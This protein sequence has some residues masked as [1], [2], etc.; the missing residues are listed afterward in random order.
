MI[1]LP[2]AIKVGSS[3]Y[4]VIRDSSWVEEEDGDVYGLTCHQSN[5]VYIAQGMGTDRTANVAL[6]E[7]LHVMYYKAG[8]NLTEKQ[9]E[10]MISQL[11]PV[12]LD[13]IRD[14]IGLVNYLIENQ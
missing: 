3:R 5:T 8:I 10:Q 13:F 9:E 14:N 2:R 12:L 6:H 7:A 11:T 1:R 4:R